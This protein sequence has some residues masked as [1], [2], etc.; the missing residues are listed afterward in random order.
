VALSIL[1]EL[2]LKYSSKS[3]VEPELKLPK[4]ISRSLLS[5]SIFTSNSFAIIS[6]V[7]FARNK[8]EDNIISMLLP[9]SAQIFFNSCAAFQF[10]LFRFPL[11]D[12]QIFQEKKKQCFSH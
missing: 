10:A 2:F 6:A 7:C 4:S 12:F 9:C 11:K 8:S 3:A 5:N 1:S